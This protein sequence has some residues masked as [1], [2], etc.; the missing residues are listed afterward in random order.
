MST[1]SPSYK[2]Q[3]EIQSM[4]FTFGEVRY[5]MSSSLQLVEDI[6]HTQAVEWMVQA[7]EPAS[8]RGSKTIGP[9]DLIFLVRHEPAKVSRLKEFLS[10]K[11]VRKNVKTTEPSESFEPGAPEE[12]KRSKP[13]IA[14]K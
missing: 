4:M 6:L 10:W 7:S 5:P 11:E 12:G 13:F 1:S 2:Y 14:L 3:T 9:E 8:L